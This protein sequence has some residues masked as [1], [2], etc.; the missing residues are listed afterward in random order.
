[1]GS[2]CTATLLPR[3]MKH[4]CASSSSSEPANKQRTKKNRKTSKSPSYMSA[5]K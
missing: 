2:R 3:A 1:M 5:Y 4:D